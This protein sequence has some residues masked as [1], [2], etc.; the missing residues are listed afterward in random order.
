MS[1]HHRR[2]LL[3]SER[4][5]PIQTLTHNLRTL[6]NLQLLDI[7]IQGADLLVPGPMLRP[8]APIF[9]E[10]LASTAILG[11]RQAALGT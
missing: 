6:R 2:S 3:F 11:L 7:Q 5:P 4:Q 8:G 9:M 10:T 1:R